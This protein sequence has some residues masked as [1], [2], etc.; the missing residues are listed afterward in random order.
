[1][2]V[3]RLERVAGRRSRDEQLGLAVVPR[4]HAGSGVQPDGSWVPVFEGQREPFARGNGLQVTHGAYSPSRVM[5]RAELILERVLSDPEIPS[6]ARSGKFRLTA[7]AFARAEAMSELL[8][9]HLATLP[10]EEWTVPPRAGAVKSPLDVW[11][12]VDAHATRLRNDL[13]VSPVAYA[14]IAASLGTAAR[15]VEDRLQ[16]M[17]ANGAR[18]VEARQAG[19]P[20]GA[21]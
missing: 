6:Q 8:L 3:R 19:E 15:G 1:M 17:A 5:E 2:A 20:R 9:E 7:V 18:F 11:K 10:P 12:T 4:A 13:G 14:R 21:D 16:A